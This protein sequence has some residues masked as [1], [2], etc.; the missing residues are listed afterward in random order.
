MFLVKSKTRVKARK[1]HPDS[2]PGHEETFEQIAEAYSVLRDQLK[3]AE[4]DQ[5]VK[6]DAGGTEGEF[7][8]AAEG[9]DFERSFQFL[10]LRYSPVHVNFYNGKLRV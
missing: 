1:Y 7:T 9:N 5:S 3:R 6:F 2:N 10:E 4:Y 8:D